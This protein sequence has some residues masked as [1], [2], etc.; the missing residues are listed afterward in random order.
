MRRR[1][2]IPATLLIGTGGVMLIYLLINI[3]YIQGLGFQETQQFGS[4]IAARTLELSWGAEAGK[5]M[6][7]LVM[8][9]ALGAING[10]LFAG[11]RVSSALG[12]EHS[13]FAVLGRWHPT[14]G[15]P[16]LALLVLA[17]MW[18][19]LIVAVGTVAGRNTIDGILGPIQ[20]GPIPW[21][22]K[23]FGDGFDMLFAA[24]A[25]VF[26]TFFLLTGLSLFILRTKD[27]G[28]DRPFKVPLYPVLP[29]IFCGMSVFGLYRAVIWAEEVSFLGIAP[30]LIA[31]PLYLVS[32]YQPTQESQPLHASGDHA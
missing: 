8:I 19:F 12:K 4:P 10:L 7:I 16:V 14:L 3:A 21:D 31:V 15:S 20:T 23:F 24:S 28:I 29:L 22:S 11:G 26:W 17:G 5:V 30:L 9:S 25:P 27:A 2:Q 18:L 1:S 6:S 13:V 32:R